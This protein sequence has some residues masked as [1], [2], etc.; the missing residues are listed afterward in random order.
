MASSL[1]TESADRLAT[2]QEIERGDFSQQT[3]AAETS[4]LPFDSPQLPVDSSQ[5]AVESSRLVVATYNIRYGVGS[6][7]IGGS[8][9]RSLGLGWPGRRSRLVQSNILKAARILS[10]GAHMPRADVIALQEA[11]RATV[12]AGGQHVARGLAEALAMSYVRAHVP[13]PDDVEPKDRKWWLDFEERMLRGEDGDT[14][15]AILSRLPLSD[16]TRIE[17]PWGECPWRPRLALAASVPFGKGKL[18]IFNSHID[19]H[20]NVEGQ[21]E[22]HRTVLALAERASE[23]GPAV[24]L[25]D[26]NTI[27]HEARL[28]ARALLES[29]GYTTPLPTGTPTWRSGPLRYHFD[30]IFTR[31][32]SVRRWGVARVTGISDHWPVW[33][34]IEPEKSD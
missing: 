16:A 3:P 13:T 19:T 7:L 27:T 11:D 24:L 17:L 14:G 23:S 15:V 31:G 30:W 1:Q 21:L 6:H 2:E 18:H 12:R 25:G 34:E 26:F 10:H 20:A 9:L 28:G 5:L 29:R 22:Q 33:I 4:R 8:L 32:V